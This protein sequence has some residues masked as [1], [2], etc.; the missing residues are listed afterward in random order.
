VR[1]TA[2]AAAAAGLLVALAGGGASYAATAPLRP[3]GAVAAARFKACLVTD[4]GGISDRSF[5]QLSWQGMQA[6]AA[7]EPR[8]IRALVLPS[9]ST[10]DYARNIAAFVKVGC[11]LIVTVGFLTAP[12]AGAAARA[13]PH[14]RF[15]IVDCTYRSGCL[16]GRKARNLDQLAFS[17]VQ[18]AFLGGY[19][20]AATSKNHVVA[21]FGGFRFGTVTIDMDGFWDGVQYYN[22]RHHAHVRVLGWNERTQKGVFAQSFTDISAGRRIAR[23]FIRAG[24]DV[25]FPVAGGTGLGTADA[26]R[27]ADVAGQHATLEWPDTDG[28][29]SIPQYCRHFLTSVT[30]GIASEVRAVVLAAAHG[31]FPRI[32]TGTLANGGVALA[33]YHHLARSV[34]ARLRAQLAR[35][36]AKIE[37][38]TITPATRS[39]V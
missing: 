21:T 37:N 17:T 9:V 18:D 26:V 1:V 38:G 16:T 3:P 34:P 6:A 7:A 25:I 12:A 5:D 27:R 39:P 4:T 2:R 11:G 29:F 28:C 33:P 36:E 23:R 8:R 10:A 22:A 24:A 30:K 35:I 20:A 14:R 15:A 32:Y 13:H 31:T 19:L